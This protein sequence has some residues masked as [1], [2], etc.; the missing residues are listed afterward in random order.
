VRKFLPLLLIAV[1]LISGCGYVNHIVDNGYM[2]VRLN[3]GRVSQVVGPGRYN[4]WPLGFFTGI[5][6]VN[7]SPQ[8][9]EWADE[10]VG[11]RE[12]QTI[13]VRV[14]VTYRRDQ[15]KVEDMWVNWNTYA[16]DD[17]ILASAVQDRIPGAVKDL[18]TNYPL[19]DILGTEGSEVGRAEVTE[20]LSNILREELAEFDVKLENVVIDNVEPSAA[21]KEVNEERALEREKKRLE[22][23]RQARKSLELKTE[24]AQ[25]AI[26]KEIA[27][28]EQEVAAIK[29]KTFELSPEALELE[30]L[31]IQVEA[32]KSARVIFL[33]SDTSLFLGADTLGKL[34]QP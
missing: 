30:K 14:T 8:S 16:K 12:K 33:P 6:D 2:A 22:E 19:D 21:Y 3:D 27:T 20:Y 29:A 4:T 25:T 31:R 26:D 10:S 34:V 7:V 5:A 9:V 15:L 17:A 23:D 11:T 32:L 18:T 1:L 13:G 24:Q 28:R